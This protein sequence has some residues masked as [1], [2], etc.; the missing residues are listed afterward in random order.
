VFFGAC[1]PVTA[2]LLH[3]DPASYSSGARLSLSETEPQRKRVYKGVEFLGVDPKP[4]RSTHGQAEA[5]VTPSG[6]P[7]GLLLQKLPMSCG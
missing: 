7:N 2:C 4:K 5:R 6:G 3:Y 1:V